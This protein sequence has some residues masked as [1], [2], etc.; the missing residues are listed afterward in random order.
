MQ[1][2]PLA[3]SS[4]YF[5]NPMAGQLDLAL[6]PPRATT[7]AALTVTELVSLVR[8]ALAVLLQIHQ[9]RH[10]CGGAGFF[11]EDVERDRVAERVRRPSDGT[12]PV[13]TA[14]EGHH[15]LRDSHL[16]GDN[17]TEVVPRDDA[18]PRAYRAFVAFH[19]ILH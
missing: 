15:P 16:R 9:A 18:G 10:V 11:L 2:L 1:A 8:D 6:G 7:S 12:V 19:A 4:G 5:V 13:R 3:E 17:R 14:A